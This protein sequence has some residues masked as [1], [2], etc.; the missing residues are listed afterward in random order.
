MKHKRLKPAVRKDEILAAAL[1]LAAESNYMTLTR[2]AIARAA[3][4]S[5]PAVQYHFGTLAQLQNEVIRAALK[6]ECLPV[7]AQGVLAKDT[8]IMQADEE[9]RARAIAAVLSTN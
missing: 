4:V 9:L 3:G 7:I 1:Q 8:R 5:G 2:N 6:Q